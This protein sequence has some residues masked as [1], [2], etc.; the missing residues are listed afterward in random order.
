MGLRRPD[1]VAIDSV[2]LPCCA[3]GRRYARRRHGMVSRRKPRSV[4]L[5]GVLLPP[6]GGVDGFDLD[7]ALRA[8]RCTGRLAAFGQP[9]ITHIAL[10]DNAALRVVL[11]GSVG[12]VPST[13]LAADACLAAV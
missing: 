2:Q 7:G 1:A 10:A 12:A 5:L 13:V 8:R 6:A 3:G 11:R 4:R 9:P